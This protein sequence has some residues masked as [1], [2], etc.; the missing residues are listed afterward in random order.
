[1]GIITFCPNEKLAK[2]LILHRGIHPVI[3]LPGTTHS[4][5]AISA[6]RDSKDL[7]FVQP[8]DEVV[9]VTLEP[10]EGV[11]NFGAMTVCTVPPDGSAK[12]DTKKTTNQLYPPCV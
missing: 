5:K 3:Q 8:G 6:L 11:G 9:V 2:Q 4:K 12:R 10:M 1:M 7:G